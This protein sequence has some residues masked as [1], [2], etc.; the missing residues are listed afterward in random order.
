MRSDQIE[1]TWRGTLISGLREH[2]GLAEEEARLK[3]DEWLRRVTQE[4]RGSGTAG[5]PTAIR[6][7]TRRRAPG[8][9]G[10][11]ILRQQMTTAHLGS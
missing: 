8:R 11:L 10:L 2:F 1:Q 6:L 5:V 7:R 4:A 3:V 9:T